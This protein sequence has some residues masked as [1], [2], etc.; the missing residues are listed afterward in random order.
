MIITLLKNLWK[1]V[2]GLLPGPRMIGVSVAVFIAGSAVGGWAV[3]KI[4]RGNEVKAL[5]KT[6]SDNQATYESNVRIEKVRVAKL[7][8]LIKE[9]PKI[10]EA[11]SHVKDDPICDL[12]ADTAGVLNLRV[13]G[14][15]VR[16]NPDTG[17]APKLEG[18][19]QGQSLNA[20]STAAESFY[21]LR[22][23]ALSQNEKYKGCT[24]ICE[25]RK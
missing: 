7:I 23:D 5:E 12:P 2:R 19:S 10:K 14:N 21:A 9:R 11:I 17:A 18:I 16:A 15:P 20:L 22:N 8:S 1:F 13:Q 24:V 25:D 6:I 3:Y 4:V